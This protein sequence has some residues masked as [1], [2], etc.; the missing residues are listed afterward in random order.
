MCDINHE[1]KCAQ[2]RQPV[3]YA[4]WIFKIFHTHL[5]TNT[6]FCDYSGWNVFL[7]SDIRSTMKEAIHPEDPLC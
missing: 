1:T 7:H 3:F 4:V 2:T 6:H 5:H